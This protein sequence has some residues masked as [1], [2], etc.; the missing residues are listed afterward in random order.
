MTIYLL[1]DPKTRDSETYAMDIDLVTSGFDSSC[2]KPS[3]R[4]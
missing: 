3:K 2:Y 1:F 4:R